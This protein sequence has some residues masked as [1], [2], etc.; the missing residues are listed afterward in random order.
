MS[1]HDID[2]AD[3]WEAIRDA[4]DEE[5]YLSAPSWLDPVTG[6]RTPQKYISCSGGVFG[7]CS[8][9]IAVY[10]MVVTAFCDVCAA[11]CEY[12]DCVLARFEHYSRSEPGVRQP[13]ELLENLNDL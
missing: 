1:V 10:A 3:L 5:I 4:A 7:P 9:V 6:K 13:C 2:D 8:R 12:D 11:P